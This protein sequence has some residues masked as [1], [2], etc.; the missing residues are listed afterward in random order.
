MER[1]DDNEESSDGDEESDRDTSPPPPSAAASVASSYRQNRS[2][3]NNATPNTSVPLD[4]AIQEVVEECITTTIRE[5]VRANP[6]SEK[7]PITVLQE[8]I[9]E[10]Q[11]ELKTHITLT[12]NV[13]RSRFH[14]NQR[15]KE[16][17]E[18][19]PTEGMGGVGIPSDVKEEIQS[20]VKK[21]LSIPAGLLSLCLLCTQLPLPCCLHPYFSLLRVAPLLC[22]CSLFGDDFTYNACLDLHAFQNFDLRRHLSSSSFSCC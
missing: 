4:A 7:I 11:N 21:S 15:I 18:R 19:F 20:V 22:R 6:L 17:S 9:Q 16:Y 10:I 2:Q 5:T 3:N 13:S 1:S 8:T 14:W 12:V